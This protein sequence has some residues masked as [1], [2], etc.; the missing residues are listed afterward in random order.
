MEK[1]WKILGNEQGQRLQIHGKTVTR[2]VQIF[3]D[4][5]YQ[6]QLSEV[7]FVLGEK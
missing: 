4:G 6:P 3:D 2:K 1:R 5:Q 7:H